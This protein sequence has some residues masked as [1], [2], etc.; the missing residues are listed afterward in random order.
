MSFLKTMGRFGLRIPWQVRAAACLGYLAF[1]TW[2]LLVSAATVARFYPDLPH[3]DKAIHILSFGGLVLLAR[4][5][6]PDPQHLAVPG[7]L[8]PV[9]ALAYGA[10]ME[11]TQGLLV[12]YHRSFEW[13]DIA[14][15]G[16]GA[17]SFWWLSG[18]LL[19]QVPVVGGK[20]EMSI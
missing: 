7:W 9:L 12:Q 20:P 3:E 19:A 8:V 15:N 10:A 2:L 14:A 5:A 1:L 18:C 11:V 4:F 13:V 16:L 17:A 6:F